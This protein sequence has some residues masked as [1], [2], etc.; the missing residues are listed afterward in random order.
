MEDVMAMR[1]FCFILLFTFLLAMLAWIP[2]NSL[3]SNQNIIVG[4]N[5]NMVE[6]QTLPGGDPWLQRQNEPSMAVSTRNPLHLLAGA[7]D[8]RTVDIPI[9]GEELPGLPEGA[10][11]GDAWLGVFK[12]FD[13]GESWMSTLLPG[14]PQ[15]ISFEGTSSPLFGFQAAADPTVRTGANGLFYYSGIA[16]NRIEHGRSV[17]FIARYIDNNNI[18]DPDPEND[19]IEY[20]DTKI[21]DEGTSGQFADKPWIA[22]DIPRSGGTVQVDG[23][24]I[25]RHNVYIVYSLFL[26]DLSQNVHNKILFARSTDCGNTWEHPIKLS[27][28]QRIN[29]GT[30]LAVDPKNGTI[31][32]AWRRFASEGESD[33]I[34]FCK[35]T[36]GGQ[37][38]SKATVAAEIN[39]FDQGT[40]ETSFR[41]NAFPTIAVD[42]NNNVYLAWSERNLSVHNNAGEDARIVIIS[43]KNGKGWPPNPK[44]V[45]DYNGHGHQIMPSLTFA[46][47]KLMMAWYDFREDVAGNTCNHWENYISD[48]HASICEWRHTVDVRVAQADPG[49]NPDF[50]TSTQVSKYYWIMKGEVCYQAQFNPPNY[51]LFKQGTVP[52]IGDYIDIC[53]SPVFILENG[54]WRF[55]TKSDD[56]SIFHVTWTDNRD[57]RPPPPPLYDWTNYNPPD[58]GQVYPQPPEFPHPGCSSGKNTGMRNQ[59]VYTSRIIPGIEVGS[60]GNTKSLSSIRPQAFVVCVKNTTDEIKNLELIIVN[61]PPDAPDGWASFI[62]PEPDEEEI[63]DLLPVNIAPHSSISRPVFVQSSYPDASIRINVKEIGGGLQGFIVLNPDPTNPEVVLEDEAHDPNVGGSVVEVNLVNANLVNANLVNQQIPDVNLVNANLVNFNPA[64]NLVNANLVNANLVNPSM[65]SSVNLVNVNL[66][67]ASVESPDAVTDIQWEVTND[68]NTTSSYTFRSVAPETLPEGL[69]AQL[70]IYRAHTTPGTDGQNCELMEVPHHEVLVNLVNPHIIDPN[71]EDVNLVNPDL[72]NSAIWNATFALAPGEKAIVALRIIRETGSGISAAEAIRA[73]EEF[74]QN[75]G[76]GVTSHALNTDETEI[77]VSTTPVQIFTL[78][79]PNGVV[80]TPYSKYL[81]IFG[82]TGPYTW[83]IPPGR[84]PKG[85]NLVD[86]QIDE[87]T[88]E[89]FGTPEFDSNVSYPHTHTFALDVTDSNMDSDTKD[90]SIKILDELEILTADLPAGTLGEYYSQTLSAKGGIGDYE[91]SISSGSLPEG[92]ELNTSTGEISRTPTA[93][94]TFNFTVKVSDPGPPE[95]EATKDLSIIILVLNPTIEGKVNFR[96][97]GLGGVTMEVRDL[98]GEL[99]LTDDTDGNGSYSFEVDYGWTGTV[100]PSS[101]EE[102][103]F[104]PPSRKYETPVFANQTGQ[105]YAAYKEDWVVPYNNDSVNGDEEASAI[106]ADNGKAHVTGYSTGKTTGADY[107]TIKYDSSGIP[108]WVTKYDGPSHEGDFATDVIVDASGNVYVTGYSYRG[109]PVKHSDYCTIRYDSSGDVVWEEKYDSRRNGNDVATA[110]AVH[111]TGV[112]VTGR[113][114]ESLGSDEKD[115]DFYT[116]MY[117]ISNG[118]R[119]WD[120]R[121]DGPADDA[122]EATAI[123]VDSSGNV[124]VTGRSIGDGTDFEYCTIKY[125]SSGDEEWV[126]RYSN[127]SV[128]G[129]DVATAIAVDSSGIYVTGR[130]IGDGTDF[131]YCTI[132]YNSSGDEEWVRR[133]SNESVNGDDKA[134]AIAIDEWGNVYVT[135]RSKGNGTDFDYC[136]VKYDSSG[137]EKWAS[138]YNGPGDGDDEATAMTLDSTGIYVTGRSKGNGTNYDYATVK[139]DFSGEVILVARYEGSGDDEAKAIAVESRNIYITGTSQ[140]SGT[141]KDY[142]TVKYIH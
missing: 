77:S 74:T 58:P 76:V 63:V 23:Q 82:G 138:R 94:G 44:P 114:E 125:N 26:G 84:L 3:N 16:F 95:Q 119:I 133:Y 9:L 52:F 32:V 66:V 120:N 57:V 36:D 83:Y 131:D 135:G 15:D 19:P 38:F 11:A 29:Q 106:A 126:R 33:A 134:T 49:T 99:I 46:A 25:P 24:N 90:L 70:I 43:G 108:D 47:G 6:G 1:R 112:C 132:K 5:V 45:D 87:Y 2:T 55:N 75:I 34:M 60:L 115:H 118:K 4:R 141:A 73:A 130:S 53:P 21:I 64:A 103:L 42:G 116:V 41:T 81:K 98:S 54:A 117:A 27:E 56:P 109:T 104:Y 30:T 14:Y 96:G 105:D 127:E 61:Q 124:Y 88:R 67:N 123:A 100:T 8:Y 65:E 22:A 48:D 97:E 128:N 86:P 17:V 102:H 93:S 7:N 35:S 31:Y 113:S 140:G 121:Y 59:N 68:G 40:T 137:N 12:S 110:I 129:D 136:T 18:E 37:K 107:A 101:L 51:P 72:E 91:W 142:V 80:G 69:Y 13:G 20:I 79:L 85:L 122:D 28:S 139:Y 71:V 10:A 89:I 92:L 111:S 62:L 78:T 50:G 39:P